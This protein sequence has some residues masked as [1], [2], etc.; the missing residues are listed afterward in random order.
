VSQIKDWDKIK[1]VAEHLPNLSATGQVQLLAALADCGQPGAA[2][3]AVMGAAK[4][5]NEEVR[6]AALKALAVLGD[7]STVTL[8]AEIAAL[9][10]GAERRTARE[11]L[12]SLKGAKVDERIIGS[13]LG[14][15]PGVKVELVRS[16]AQ[17]RINAGAKTLLTTVQDS[18][19]KVRLESWKAL[20]VVDN[21]KVPGLISLMLKAQSDT[22]RREAEKTVAAVANT[23]AKSERAMPILQQLASTDDVDAA[24]SLLRVLGKTGGDGGLEMLRG[25]LNEDDPKLVDA[26]IRGLVEWP[27]DEPMAEL[28]KIAQISESEVHRVLALR[29]YV[30][31]IGLEER[32]PKE[33]VKMYRLA[34]SQA[35]DTSAK[36]MVLSGLAEVKSVAAMK[37][38]AD[39]VDD[40]EL[41][42]EAASAAAASAAVRI[43]GDLLRR[44]LGE[45][46]RPILEKI[47][48]TAR[49]EDVREGAQ[50][51]I[52]WIEE[53]GDDDD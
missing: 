37:F 19:S 38:V 25:T 1:A 9:S 5:R 16:I 15:E 22:E 10:T 12:Y 53:E 49:N 18:D 35:A 47:A 11:S 50:E 45:Q 30:R 13:V 4:S 21:R 3:A 14:A 36:K 31:M 2:R 46:C 28:F 24:C 51:M 41:G 6:I 33:A 29:G 7:E 27:D 23:F 48:Q 43:V 34:M 17:R 52:G 40:D 8:L 39:Y 20:R 26:A 42:A 32:S 44:G